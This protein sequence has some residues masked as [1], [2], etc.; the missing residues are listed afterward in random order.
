MSITVSN[1]QHCDEQQFRT[2]SWIHYTIFLVVNLDLFIRARTVIRS[3]SSYGKTTRTPRVRFAYIL[4][5]SIYDAHHPSTKTN[6]NKN[7]N[8]NLAMVIIMCVFHFS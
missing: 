1:C 6:M 2:L 5:K 3:K 7:I 4:F 8:K